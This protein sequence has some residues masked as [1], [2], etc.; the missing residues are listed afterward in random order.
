[1]SNPPPKATL[2][3]NVK[4]I[5]ASRQG[6]VQRLLVEEPSR[7]NSE[8]LTGRTECNRL[9]L[10]PAPARLLGQMVDVRITEAHQRSL[11]GEV[12]VS[13]TV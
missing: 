7:S 11:R 4:R 2:D 5:S 1:M 6:T 10:F 12:L 9:V 8:L 13:E 3:E